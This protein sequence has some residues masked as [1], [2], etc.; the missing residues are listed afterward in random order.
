MEL[1]IEDLHVQIE[2]K[3]IIK[4]LDLTVK[5]GEVV[6]L[7][8]PNGSGKSTLSNVIM[9]HPAYEVTKGRI[10]LDGKDLFELEPDERA[11]L[12]LFLSFQH[13]VEVPGLLVK[14][15]LLEIYK[16]KTASKPSFMEFRKL[17]NETMDKLHIKRSFA[18]RYLNQGFSGGEKKR[19]EILQM[20]LLRPEFAVL[21]ETDSGLDIDALR[22]VSEGVNML[23]E[24]KRMGV[25]VITH[26]KR[27][28]QELKPD[29]VVV[30]VEGSIAEQGGPELADRLEAEGYSWATQV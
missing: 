5:S 20:A 15:F 7:M 12:G 9:G 17:L 11:K 2:G 22:K 29:R 16:A 19:M 10:S 1:V 28:L 6:A 13:P 27:I 3:D 4:G 21:D 26:Y 8:G 30:L 24:E 23:R 18:N 25:L 14:D